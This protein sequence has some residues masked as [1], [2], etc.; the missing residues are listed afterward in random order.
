MTWNYTIEKNNV[1]VVKFGDTEGGIVQ[2]AF[3]D[4]TPWASKA[5][6]TAWAEAKVAELTDPTAPAAGNSPDAITVER[7]EYVEPELP[8]VAEVDPELEAGI[9]DADSTPTE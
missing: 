5:Q 8:A 7:G 6:A 2:P 3:P 1:V 4:G 9:E